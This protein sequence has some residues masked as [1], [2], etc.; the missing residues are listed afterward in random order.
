MTQHLHTMNFHAIHDQ[1][2]KIGQILTVGR[3]HRGAWMIIGQT[4]RTNAMPVRRNQRHTRIEPDKRITLHQRAVCET[5]IVERIG[6][7]KDIVT[8]ERVVAE[9]DASRGF[10]DLQTITRLKKLPFFINQ[11]H[12][13]DRHAE[14][15]GR[16]DSQSIKGF[17]GRRIHQ[18]VLGKRTQACDFTAAFS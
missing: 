8:F 12:K 11:R 15:S 10:C 14:Q 16:Q 5:G 9:R 7:A 2:G 18:M 4:E 13:C 17:I 6:N 3:T 1:C